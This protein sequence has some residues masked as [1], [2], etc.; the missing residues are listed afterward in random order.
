MAGMRASRWPWR[1]P[2]APPQRPWKHEPV[3]SPSPRQVLALAVV[4]EGGLVLL[5]VAL[6]WITSRPAL[7]LIQPTWGALLI[8]VC[9][10]AP[11]VPVL[12]FCLRSEWR[13]ME[14]LRQEV[15]RSIAPYFRHASFLDISLIAIMAGLGEELLF[16]GVVQSGL[17]EIVGTTL[18]VLATSFVFG[19]LHLITPTYAFLAGAFGLYLGVLVVVTG[20]VFVPVV[21]HA[22]YDVVALWVL[23]ERGRDVMNIPDS[24]RAGSSVDSTSMSP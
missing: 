5:A 2:V 7:G 1:F 6:G 16:R 4:F 12:L 18:A 9:A 11:L 23:R 8:G 19:L 14:R 22:A 3:S 21:A 15:D 24:E 13:P 17:S 20:D 10:A